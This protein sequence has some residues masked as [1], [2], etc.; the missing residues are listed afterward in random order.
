MKYK[1]LSKIIEEYIPDSPSSSK[2]IMVFMGG[3]SKEREVS[4]SSGKG[5]TQSLKKLGYKFTAVDIGNDIAKIVDKYAPD[6]V[7]N[8]LH[9]PYGEDGTI[10]GM[11]DI[12]QVPYTH[13][14]VLSSAICMDKEFFYNIM[15]SHNI[16]QAKRQIIYR[17]EPN[18]TIPKPFVVKPISEGSSIG[19]EII[20]ENDE[21]DINKYDWKDWDRVI[22]EQYIPGRELQVAVVNDK[23]VGVLEIVTKRKFYDYIAKYVP[24]NADHIINPPMDPTKLEEILEISNKVHKISKCKDISRVEFRYNDAKMGGDDE[25]YLLEINTHPGFTPISIV[26]EIAMH[27]GISYEDIVQILVENAKCC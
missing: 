12:M 26:P 18:I 23:A 14:G 13:S 10:P 20:L 15:A 11:L 25:F 5:V 27:N 24:G 9:G 8:A 21:F 19:V 4:L 22:V 6:V 17:D 16:K 1:Q 3:L 2:H 7:F